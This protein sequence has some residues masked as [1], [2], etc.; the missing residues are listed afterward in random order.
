MYKVDLHTHSLVSHDGSIT[1][2]QY[3][4][5]LEQAQLDCIAI[6]DHNRIDFA[7]SMHQELGDKIIVGEEIM[8]SQGEIIGLYLKKPVEPH[9]TAQATAKAIK[10][11][12]GIVY[13]PHPFETV[14]HGLS[15]ATLDAI[16]EHVD[17]I[18]VHNGRA[19]FQ[20]R[21]KRALLWATMHNVPWAAS[22]DAHGAKGLCNTYTVLS[23]MPARDTLVDLNAKGQAMVARPPLKTLLYPK[24]NRARKKINQLKGHSG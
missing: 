3:R 6:T 9:Q 12:G 1:A 23:D 15:E 14:R 13:I 8:T 22:S 4:F 20:D 7:L 10:K 21:S 11:Q 19:F 18:E 24:F 17:L 2:D 16:Q 5:V